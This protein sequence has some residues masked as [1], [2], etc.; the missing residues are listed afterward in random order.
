MDKFTTE[1]RVKMIE[2]CFINGRSISRNSDFEWPPRF[3][4]LTTPAFGM[5]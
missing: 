4:D 2:F 3:P 1:Q 5:F